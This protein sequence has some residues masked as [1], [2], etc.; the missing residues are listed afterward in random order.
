MGKIDII[1][2]DDSD[3]AEYEANQKG[4]RVDVIVRINQELYNVRIYSLDRLEQDFRSECESYGYY[5]VEPNLV[6]VNCVSKH[7]VEF[8]LQKLFEQK[9]FGQIKP[10]N[11]QEIEEFKRNYPRTFDNEGNN[12]Y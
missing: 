8:T 10:M 12:L 5:A 7:E 2:L 3:L 4:Y 1:Y 9:Y 11:K 6:L